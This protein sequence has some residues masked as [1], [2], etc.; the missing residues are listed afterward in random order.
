MAFSR[1]K[2]IVMKALFIVMHRK[3][4]SP[5]QRFRHEQ[6]LS[7]LEAN[8][9]ECEIS[10]IIDEKADKFF[11]KPGNYAKKAF[12][13]LDSIYRR[14]SD[15][16][17]AK[18]SD[19]VFLYRE[20]LFLGST[21]FER[22]IQKTSAK[23]IFDF[24]DA[25]WI[26]DVSNANRLFS[27]LKNPNK[28]PQLIG[29]VDRVFAGNQ[30]LADY[31]SKYNPSVAIIPTTIDTEE[32]QRATL[33]PK[34]KVCIGWSGSITTIKH[35]EF[36]LPFLKKIKEKYGEKVYFKV[37]GDKNYHHTELGIQGYPWKKDTEILDLSEIDIGIMPL[38]NDKWAKGKCGLKGLQYMALEIPTLMS[39]VGVNTEIIQDGENGFL[40]EEEGEWVD[41]ISRL[42]EDPKLREDMGN[43]GRATVLKHYSVEA[44][45]DVYLQEFMQLVHEKVPGTV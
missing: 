23:T 14:F 9:F 12:V 19:I 17:K 41:K 5:G 18:E 37:I 42:V 27:F 26:Q 4:R 28:T 15:L 31:A 20:A 8:G 10:Y 30:Y 45:K 38:P 22:Q 44:L 6:Y 35:F 21:W 29:L 36:A 33:P 40:A 7:Y 32:Y 16:K 13:A 11:Y 43:A 39:P 25:I 34:D 2:S 1:R 3:D 24:D